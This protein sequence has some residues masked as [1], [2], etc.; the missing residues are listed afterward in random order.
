MKRYIIRRLAE[1][2]PTTFGVL[3]LTFL[4]FHV[5]GSSSADVVLG[6]NAPAE[7][8]SPNARADVEVAVGFNAE[9]LDFV[10][11]SVPLPADNDAATSAR[12]TLVDGTRDGNGA[13]LDA[14]HDGAVPSGED[15]PAKNF[16]F[17]AGTDGGRIAVDLGRAIPVKRIGTY[18]WHHGSR[19]PQVYVL[20]ASD[21]KAA[22]FEQAPKRGVDPAAR[23]WTFV[24]RVDTRPKNGEGGGQHGVAITSRGGV[25]GTFRHLL[26][27]IMPTE[28]RDAFGNTFFS[29]ID[30]IDANGPALTSRVAPVKR[31]RSAFT[32][33]DGAFRFVIDSTDA[34][35]LTEWADQALKPVVQTWYPELVALLASDG[36][37]APA[38]VVLR[39]R[40]DMGGTPAS[41]GGRGVNLNAEWFRREQEREALG[42][43]V[44]ELVH[45]VQ[46]YGR[47]KRSD[48]RFA[49]VPGWLVEGIADYIRWFLYEPEKRGAE[50]TGRR[51]AS[52]RYDGSYRVTAN[53]LDWVTRTHDKQLIGKLN[54]AAR[55]GRYSE[56]L[57]ITWTGKS[58]QELGEEWK[59]K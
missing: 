27:D 13:D 17:Q 11:Q 12:F 31:I 38:E 15:Q 46:S 18:S 28:R 41:A 49:P 54:A 53:F 42:C 47:A 20:Y 37:Q 29:E 30:V 39:F 40:N 2:G 36:Y 33:A 3:V 1:L 19:G 43:V 56:A 7:T 5:V 35:D 52:V 26:F 6:K 51:L 58:V 14:L 59:G 45:V 34:P 10:F 50:I 4:L 48:P 57:W 25:V 55:E 8:L 9:D 24:A 23:G 21:G 32:A 44:H 16:F 22:G